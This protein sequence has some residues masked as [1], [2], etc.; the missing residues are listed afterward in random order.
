MKPDIFDGSVPLREFLSQF[1]LIARA[2]LWN[3]ATKS[4]ALA[5]CLRRKARA[6]LETVE[7]LEELSFEELKS[8]LELRFGKENLT[9]NYY[10]L[11]T[12]RRQ[13]FG[14]DLASFGAELEKFSRLAYPECPFSV[15]DKIACAQ[16]ISA[17][18][19]NFIK[20]TLQLEGASSLKTAIERAKAIK[21]IQEK[22]FGWKFGRNRESNFRDS[23]EGERRKNARDKKGEKSLDEEKFENEE[24]KV[25]RNKRSAA[26]RECWTCGKSGHFRFECPERKGNAV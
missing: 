14:E 22:N 21:A 4:I 18:S 19:D 10:S 12:N 13:K 1:S 23:F 11:F 3:D 16:F 20:R 17:L 25:W 15:R 5:A 7:S 9:Q 2:N 26:N 24:R 6:I 8:K